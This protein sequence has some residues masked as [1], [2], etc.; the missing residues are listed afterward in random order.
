LTWRLGVD[1][2]TVVT[3]GQYFELEQTLAK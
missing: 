2:A 1:M 3:S